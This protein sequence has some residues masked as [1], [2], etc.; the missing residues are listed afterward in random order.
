MIAFLLNLL[1]IGNISVPLADRH[2]L[3]ERGRSL[4]LFT[5]IFIPY[6][7]EQEQNRAERL[8]KVEMRVDKAGGW[9]S[10]FRV[11]GSRAGALSHKLFRVYGMLLGEVWWR[12]M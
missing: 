4:R 8:K 2:L 3:P 12:Q 9:M 10:S 7:G 5:E 1:C 11:Q 6:T